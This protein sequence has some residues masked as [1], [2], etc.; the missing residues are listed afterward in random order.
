MQVICSNPETGV[1]VPIPQYPIYTAS[2][3]ILNSRCVPYPLDEYRNWALDLEQIRSAYIAAQSDGTDVRAIVII[4]PGNPTGAVLSEED[5]SSIIEFAA[6][7]RLVILADEVYQTNVFLGVFH[8]FKSILR[9]LQA[10]I[11]GKYDN[12]ELVSLH[13]VSKGMIGE[14]GHRG[15]Y[16]ELVGFD[17]AVVEQIYKVASISLC[18][19]VTGQC[20]VQLMVNP[21]K[22]GEPSYD[23]YIQE[24]NNTF[25]E[26]QERA[27]AIYEA[28]KE[29]QGV[30]CP[31]PQ[32]SMYLYPTISLPRGAIDKAEELGKAGDEYYCMRLLEETGICIVPGS[33]FGQKEGTLHLRT[34]FL[35]PDTEWVERMKEFHSAFMA[36][37]K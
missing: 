28:L 9:R 2:L 12:V 36:E 17:P 25:D 30:E 33:G 10:S 35:P 29:M 7:E 26:L 32:G 19:P 21:P 5:V 15:G 14:C 8:S 16:F 3:S 18:A 4:N 37:F 13:S 23:L 20:M 24:Y 1:L 11:Q 6:E 34:T 31:R 22:E 27:T